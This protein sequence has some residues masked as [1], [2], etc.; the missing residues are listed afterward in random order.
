MVTDPA[1]VTEPRPFT[2]IDGYS[3]SLHQGTGIATYARGLLHALN[4]MNHRVGILHG[5]PRGEESKHALGT[6]STNSSHNSPSRITRIWRRNIITSLEVLRSPTLRFA[7]RRTTSAPSTTGPYDADDYLAATER[8]NVPRLYDIAE[9]QYS[10]WRSLT[11]VEMTSPPERVHWTYP[12]PIRIAG[13]RNIYT[14]H[15]LIPLRLPSATLDNKKRYLS[16]L[17]RVATT[18]DHILT[19]SEN[20]KRDIVE[21]LN[22]PDEKISNTYQPVEIPATHLEETPNEIAATLSS[23]LN[24]KYRNYYLFFGAIEPKK[25]INRLVQAYIST[26]TQAPLVIAGPRAW[27]PECLQLIDR[28]VAGEFGNRVR[29]VGYLRSDRLIRLIRGAKATIFPSLYEGFGL[30]VIESMLLGTPVITSNTSALP[31]IAGDAAMQVSPY[32]IGEI[33]AAITAIDT[34]ASLRKQ[35][36]EKGSIRAKRFNRDSFVSRLGKIP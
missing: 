7:A 13:A 30:P 21:L 19:V 35:L 24:L 23:E 9:Q 20:S 32:R 14:I 34:S 36:T 22:I 8:F 18:A 4:S 1:K 15:D 33:G 27:G 28:V 29:Y 10:N 11:T 6:I 12:I 16:L 5:H 3:L 26:D 25:N 17:K 2:M 31:E